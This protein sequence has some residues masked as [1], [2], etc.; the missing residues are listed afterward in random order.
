ML[1]GYQS[2][3][4]QGAEVRSGGGLRRQEPP[5]RGVAFEDAAALSF[6]RGQFEEFTQ[7]WI[8]GNRI[9]LC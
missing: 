9:L 3:G 4:A 5:T 1:S 8:L 6:L 7:H 2:A